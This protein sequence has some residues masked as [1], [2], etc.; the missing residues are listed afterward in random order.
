METFLSNAYI[1]LHLEPESGLAVMKL[2]ITEKLG[3]V[4]GYSKKHHLTLDYLGSIHLDTL[5]SLTFWT[6]VTLLLA[7]KGLPIRLGA[8]THLLSDVTWEDIFYLPAES[9]NW[10]FWHFRYQWY[11][12]RTPHVT[13]L[14][15]RNLTEA[16]IHKTLF[17]IK[18]IIPSSWL[19]LM[20]SEVFCHWKD[21]NWDDITK[22]FHVI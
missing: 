10:L 22:S 16:Q 11:S 8:P 14:K 1:G 3:K 5:E 21:E 15:W 18:E 17:A 19:S 12:I 20:T 7:N 13:L 6:R 4:L 9:D 2:N